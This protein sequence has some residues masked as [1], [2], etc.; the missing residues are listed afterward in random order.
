MDVRRQ[1]RRSRDQGSPAS[2]RFSPKDAGSPTGEPASGGS[3][4]GRPFKGGRTDP[5]AQAL[6]R[7]PALS[8]LKMA[9]VRVLTRAV[10]LIQLPSGS[11]V[12]TAGRPRKGL[13]LFNTGTL[14]MD[15][16]PVSA[17]GLVLGMPA[18]CE[19]AFDAVV[20]DGAATAWLVEFRYADWVL[21][22][23]R[24]P[25]RRLVLP[26]PRLRRRLAAVR[27]ARPSVWES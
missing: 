8:H 22:Q 15:G 27:A 19:G 7:H 3:R 14:L 12:V 9:R 17:H 16:Q 20:A 5:K 25:P 6:A 11:S 10:D 4:L 13:L 2:V 21:E 18:S 1:R 24:Q 23:M 26:L